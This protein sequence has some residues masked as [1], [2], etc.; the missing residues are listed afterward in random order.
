ML[1]ISPAKSLPKS[2]L[3]LVN[4]SLVAAVSTPIFLAL[5][6]TFS[7]LAFKSVSSNGDLSQSSGNIL[8]NKTV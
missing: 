3:P 4:P 1:N 5:F 8:F 2:S 7:I 6:N